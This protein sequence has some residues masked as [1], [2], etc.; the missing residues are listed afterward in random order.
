M[1]NQHGRDDEDT[2][3]IADVVSGLSRRG[4]LS[5][6]VGGFALAAS[7]L[8]LPE[9]VEETL[10]RKGA[11]SG[12]L[13]GRRKKDR[14][15]RD[16]NRDRGEKKDKPNEDKPRGNIYALDRIKFNVEVAGSR[17]VKVDHYYLLSTHKG[18]RLALSESRTLAP[19]SSATL[20]AGDLAALWIDNRYW[21]EAE[22]R[23]GFGSPATVKMGYNGS[24]AA[25][26]V[27]WQGGTVAYN[28]H[29]DVG[30]STIPMVIDGFSTQVTRLANEGEGLY[31]YAVFK[32]VLAAPA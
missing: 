1:S 2:S 24:I 21:V 16:K 31:P 10:A 12:K 14:R 11:Y 23:F 19:G 13:G 3:P 32:V 30:Q 25:N 22:S 6:A 29:L 8:F 18:T 15:G 17:P 9:T 5:A 7:G 26:P 28:E 27:K 4:L 20:S